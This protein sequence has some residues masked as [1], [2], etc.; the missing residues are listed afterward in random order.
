MSILIGGAWPYANGSLHLG[1]IAALLPGDVIA[2]YYRSKGEDVLYVS[3]SDC[4]GTPIS[5]RA[6][7]EKVTPQEI[8]ERY[9]K[10]FQY[11]FNK[12]DFSYDYYSRTDSVHHKEEVQ[13]IIKT[14]YDNGFIYEK[15]VDQLYCSS[16]NQFLPDRFVEGICPKCK[17]IAR[18]DQ[19]DTCSTI[20]DPLD[21]CDRK[22][23]LCGDE[24]KVKTGNQL[25]FALSKFQDVLRANLENSRDY[26][27]LNAINNTERYLNEGLHDRA[28]SRDLPWGIDLPLKGYEDKKL[29]VWIDAVLGYFTVSK[30]WGIENNRDWEHFWS[31]DSTTYFVHGKDNI[32]FHSLIFPA[33]LNGIGYEINPDRI[34]SSEYITLEGKKISTSNNWAVWVN[35]VIEK[36][37]VDA[38]R[39]FL[40]ANGPEKRDTNFS[41]REF[42]NSNNGELL[43]AYGNL[44]NRTLTFVKKFFDNRIPKGEVDDEI[45]RTI[46]NLYHEVGIKIEGGNLKSAIEQIF[47]F[48]RS[49]NKYFD[50]ET[51]WIT[52]NT[53]NN[54]CRT[55]IYNCL[56]CIVNVTNLLNPFLPASSQ[57]VKGW[58]S[59]SESSWKLINLV[60]EIE[61]GEFSILFERLDKKLIEEE[62]AKLNR[63]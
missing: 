22:C 54:E 18:G 12:L 1:H 10:E 7:D 40:I 23:K 43:G 53:N 57:K 45:K 26:W 47:D 25:F 27:R 24:P 63:D 52:V 59:C 41:W 55:T 13:S 11:C 61:I 4:H 38:L 32:P 48:I 34:I 44:V 20:L 5:I 3:G 46:E 49:I 9:H 36:Y 29:Y 37:N 50:E 6:K 33:L 39:Y 62:V 58:F 35:D 2:R 19:C 28:I 30:R 51:P 15:E 31:K 17:S 14:L 21:L 42:I 60:S 8:A 56:F 16:C